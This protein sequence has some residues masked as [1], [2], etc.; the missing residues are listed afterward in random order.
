M[1]TPYLKHFQ[2]VLRPHI[3]RRCRGH[4]HKRKSLR[5]I[6]TGEDHLHLIE[7]RAVQE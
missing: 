7:K 3:G 5:L 6:M 1:K 4:Q 2:F